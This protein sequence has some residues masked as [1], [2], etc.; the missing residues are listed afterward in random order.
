MLHLHGGRFDEADRLFHSVGETWT[1]V[2]RSTSDVKELVPQLYQPELHAD[3]SK[4]LL[5]N[6]RGLRLGVR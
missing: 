4:S 3:G 5:R 6:G 2:L 1:G